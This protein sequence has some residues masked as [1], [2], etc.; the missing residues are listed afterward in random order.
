MLED[1]LLSVSLAK[2]TSRTYV[3]SSDPEILKFAQRFGVGP[4][5]E[6]SDGGV[7]SAVERAISALQH[8]DGWL[9]LPADIPLLS[10]SDIKTVLTLHR[11]G[12]QIII[13]PSED[14]SGT[15]LLLVTQKRRITLHYDDDSFNKH[16]KE[17]TASGAST[18]VY[19]SENVAFDMDHARDVHRYFRFGRRNSTMNFLERTLKRSNRVKP[20]ASGRRLPDSSRER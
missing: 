8:F 10:P 17:A 13:S 16:V 6:E 4:I 20:N 18:A 14:Y 1:I 3:V 9:I 5:Q 12:S 11:L 19:Y 2:K 7:T 15:N